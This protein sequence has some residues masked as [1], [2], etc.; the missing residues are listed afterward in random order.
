M[1]CTNMKSLLLVGGTGGWEP[2]KIGSRKGLRRPETK[3]WE[4]GHYNRC[5]VH[6]ILSYIAKC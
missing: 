6:L 3:G 5:K 1:Q 4:V 2:K